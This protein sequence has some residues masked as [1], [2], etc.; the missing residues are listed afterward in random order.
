MARRKSK[1]NFGCLFWIA[2]I[3]L[4]VVIFLFNRENTLAAW[5]KISHVIEE[6][7]GNELPNFNPFEKKTDE[8][9]PEVIKK[10]VIAEETKT[11]PSIKIKKQPQSLPK[12]EKQDINI[13]KPEK[14]TKKEETKEIVTIVSK[15]KEEKK[16][17]QLRYRRAKLYF[18]LVSEDGSIHLKAVNRQVGFEDSPLTRVI[19]EL[20]QGPNIDELNIG[21]Q[22]LIPGESRLRSAWVKNNTAFLDFNQDFQFNSIGKEGQLVQLQQIV[23]TACQFSTVEK[24]QFLIEGKQKQFLGAEGISI[25]IPLS[26]ASF[27]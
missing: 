27:N 24:V 21:L 2:I 1:N 6:K 17:S 10:T 18:A 14:E 22:S 12:E 7:T 23:N 20:I 4:V 25:N 26:P 16:S 8:K 13:K 19:E 5:Q 3:L 11:Q 15:P 9:K